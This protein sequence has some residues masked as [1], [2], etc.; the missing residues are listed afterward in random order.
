[1]F[2]WVYCAYFV[3]KAMVLSVSEEKSDDTAPH[4][5]GSGG[6]LRKVCLSEDGD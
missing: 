1:M 2:S 4:P 5:P 3:P 6:I